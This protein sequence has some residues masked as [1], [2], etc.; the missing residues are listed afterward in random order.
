MSAMGT[1]LLVCGACALV[2]AG[3]LSGCGSGA[4]QPDFPELHP[5]KG[6]IKRDG[7]PVRGGSVRFTPDPD[8]PDFVVNAEV[9]ADG[10]YALTTVRTT[11]ARGERK[12]GAPAGTYK[13]TYTPQL[14]DQTAGAQSAPVTLSKPVT[15]AAGDNDITLELPKK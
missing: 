8:G 10:T 14:G 2:A 12:T 9:G 11:D 5:A 1:R 3:L 6:V 7:Q 15:I 4:K 13:V